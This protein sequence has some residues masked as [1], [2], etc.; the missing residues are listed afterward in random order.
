MLSQ[1]H[2]FLASRA[3]SRVNVKRLAA[4]AALITTLLPCSAL[5]LRQAQADEGMW[6]PNQLPVAKLKANYNF[7]PSPAWTSNAIRSC[8]NF[9]G[10]SSSF[11]SAD[12][13]DHDQQ[14]RLRRP[15]PA[16]Q[17]AAAQ[18]LR[19]TASSRTPCPTRSHPWPDA[20]RASRHPGRDG[21]GGCRRQRRRDLTPAASAA[22]PR[23][24]DVAHRA[25][26][27]S[28]PACTARW[29]R[30]SAARSTTCTARK[31]TDDI[32]LVFKPE[33]QTG[34]FGGNADNFEYPR[35]DLDVA[36]FR[37]YENGKP[38]QTPNF[39]KF[40]PN[41][42]AD[43][44]LIFAWGHP[45]TTERYATMPELIERRDVG[46]PA[47]MNSERR[48]DYFLHQ[49]ALY[50]P[51]PRRLTANSIYG[52]ENALKDQEGQLLLGLQDPGV[53]AAKASQEAG[54]AA[55]LEA[56]PRRVP[57]L[58]RGPR[59]SGRCRPAASATQYLEAPRR[60][61]AAPRCFP[62]RCGWSRLSCSPSCPT[63]SACPATTQPISP[64]S[65]ES[66]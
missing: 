18:L 47:A 1:H 8:L 17:H 10:A 14:P 11:V 52:I 9:D 29:S 32:R 30:F 21:A 54:W 62:A 4:T 59:H 43:G 3:S 64:T 55:E 33:D 24:G 23:R 13:L 57:E 44:Q 46:I 7:Q 34:N 12:G 35:F 49:Y 37:A 45:G 22:A 31:P 6:L 40:S 48:L 41:G 20:L 66:C 5:A 27:R 61:S 65:A 50:G 36:F 26:D 51:E 56:V 25:G 60:R 19:P 63:R 38:A 53:I 2:P 16:D 42:A 15:G 58:S 28:R 39:L